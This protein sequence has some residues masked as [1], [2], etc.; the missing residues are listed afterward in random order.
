MTDDLQSTTQSETVSGV[1]VIQSEVTTKFVKAVQLMTISLSQS[2]VCVA[3]ISESHGYGCRSCY[4]PLPAGFAAVHLETHATPGTS[5]HL[6]FVCNSDCAQELVNAF[7]GFGAR[8]GLWD[9][10]HLRAWLDHEELLAGVV[11]VRNIETE[12]GPGVEFCELVLPKRIP[13]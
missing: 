10:R 8:A 2:T 5:G 12:F 13:Q 7:R 11:G 3:A 1:K 9:W 6:H 4:K